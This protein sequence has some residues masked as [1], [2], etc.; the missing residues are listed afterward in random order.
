M[1]LGGED[2]RR[3]A[4]PQGEM[5]GI[6]ALNRARGWLHAA[7]SVAMIIASAFLIRASLV[8]PSPDSS[9]PPST[10]L[11]LSDSPSKGSDKAAVALVAFSDYQCPFCA[12][13]ARNVFPRLDAQYIQPGSL[14]FVHKHF[15]LRSIH[16]L[17]FDAAVTS[18]CTPGGA[19]FWEIHDALFDS[20][21]SR[22]GLQGLAERLGLEASALQRCQQGSA[23]AKVRRDIDD[24]T[25][26][27]VTKVPTFFL[28][29]RH[30]DTVTVSAVIHGTPSVEFFAGKIDEALGAAAAPNR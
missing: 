16:P 2:G 15:P 28:G 14:L 5:T 3:V 23:A 11:S 24:G 7:A 9:P 10:S 8:R 27:G 1:R 19:R 30:H 29:R 22:L 13:F 18:E 4:V 17:A 6:S 26:L 20:G 25:R 12:Q 21:L